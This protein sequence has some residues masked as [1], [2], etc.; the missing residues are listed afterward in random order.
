[1]RSPVEGPPSAVTSAGGRYAFQDDQETPDTHV[2]SFQ[3]PDRRLITWEG[4]SCNRLGE[5]DFISFY[6][7][8][9]GLRL[10][11]GGA[12][13]LFDAA[14]KPLREAPG[15][16]GDR[17]HL[18][19]FLA[20]IRSGRPPSVDGAQGRVAVE[21][22]LALYQSAQAGGVPVDLPLARDPSLKKLGA[23]R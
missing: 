5:Q 3:F 13:T 15:T 12:F 14:G 20:A 17:E 11:D 23:K 1:M 2:V 21:V 4:H 6:G 9:G 8:K 18:L 19:D 10:G 7:E 22:I 16:R